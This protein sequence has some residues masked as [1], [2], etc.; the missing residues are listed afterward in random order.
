EQA[1]PVVGVHAHADAP[2]RRRARVPVD[3]DAPQRVELEGLL[4]VLR[5]DGDPAPARD[6][7]DDLVAGQRR[8]AA[9]EAHQHVGLAA[10]ADAGRGALLAAAAEEAPALRRARPPPRPPP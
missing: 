10:H 1:G 7:A 3:V 2:G 9:R 6:V 8:A 4:A 5:V